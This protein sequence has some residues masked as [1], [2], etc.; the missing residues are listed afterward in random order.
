MGDESRICDN[1][2][3]MR[4]RR[5]AVWAAYLAILLGGLALI[6]LTWLGTINALRTEEQA[7]VGHANSELATKALLFENQ[8]RRRLFAVDQTMRSL[9]DEW[10]RDPSGFDL[11][12]WQRRARV[13]SD[14]GV[15]FY[16]TNAQGII[17]ISS[18]RE[19]VGVDVSSQEGFRN[20]A[21]LRA[22]DGDLFIGAGLKDPVTQHGQIGL[23]RR[24]DRPNGDFAGII[25]RLIFDE[26]SKGGIIP[27]AH[28]GLEGDG[29]LGHF[30]NGANAF[31][32]H[33]H[34]VGDFIR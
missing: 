30:Q 5:R 20:R 2:L 4:N 29:L 13:I 16:V 33:L 8:V 21:G 10:E 15:Y 3:D 18:R 11:D 23:A 9:E 24:L 12:A 32:W 6:A 7:A 19:L 27:V 28:G 22:D 14:P 31:H 17:Q 1:D 26:I 25:G 34:F